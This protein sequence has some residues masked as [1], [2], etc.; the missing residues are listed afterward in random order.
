MKSLFFL[1]LDINMEA[2]SDPAT[3]QFA[4]VNIKRLFWHN[5]SK[6]QRKESR[7]MK[8]EW[9]SRSPSCFVR[10]E[11]AFGPSGRPSTTK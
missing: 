3:D 10:F 6:K 11:G 4:A 5:T 1:L 9:R 2:N 8:E 7:N